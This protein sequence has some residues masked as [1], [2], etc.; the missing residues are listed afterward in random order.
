MD[1]DDARRVL[2]L[3]AHPDD[4]D[5]HAGGTIARWAREGWTIHY[6]VFTSGDKGSDDPTMTPEALVALRE[7]E[8][9][10]AAEILG[11]QGVSFLRYGDGDLPWLGREVTEVVT[12]LI[13]EYRPQ[14]VMTHDPYA[15]P[16]RYLT[17]QLHPDHRAL[18]F[19]VIDAVYFRATGPLFYPEQIAAGLSPHRVSELYLFMGDHVDVYVDI[20]QTFEQKLAAIR[21]HVSQWG[22]HPDLEG[23]FRRR[24]EGLGTAQGLPLAEAFKRLIPN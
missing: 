5:V 3:V 22:S 8:Q 15:G 19:A 10:R 20:S 21:A 16:S 2:V 1:G 12:R 13:R 11:V 7:A 17:Y 4:A 6:V 18:G 24:A 23:F 14:V 9:R